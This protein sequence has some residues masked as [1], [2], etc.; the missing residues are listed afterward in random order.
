MAVLFTTG[1]EPCVG[2]GRPSSVELTDLDHLFGKLVQPVARAVTADQV[3]VAQPIEITGMD[4]RR[5]DDDVH[6]L[7]DGHG[8]VVADEG[9]FHQVIALAMT[10][11]PGFRRP[12]VFLHEIVESVPY[13]LARRAW[14]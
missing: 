12:A 3:I 6:V 7:R 1:I 4:I 5:M 2:D 9:T 10:I 8:L 13:V 11:E 14:L